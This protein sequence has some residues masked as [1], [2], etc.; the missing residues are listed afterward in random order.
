MTLPRAIILA[1]GVYGSTNGKTAHGLVRYSKRYEI[2]GVIDSEFS[3][4]DAGYVLDGKTRNIPIFSNVEEALYL[5][6]DILIIGAATDG[7]YLPAN[8]RPFILKAMLN[9]MNIVSGLHE[10]LSDDPEF[11]SMANIMGVQITDVRKMFLKKQEFFTGE[12]ENVKAIKVAVLG[13]DSAIGKRTTTIML[14]EALKDMGYSAIFVG[15][16]QT[17]WMQGAEYCALIDAMINDFVAGGIESEVVRAWKDHHPDFILIEGQGGILHPAYPGGFEI[18]A[19]A[20]PEAIVLQHAPKRLYYDGFEKYPI[21]DVKKFMDIIELLSGHSIVGITLNTEKMSDFEIPYYIQD[22][23]EKYRVPVDAPLYSGVS[24]IGR[25]IL[26]L[27]ESQ[28][29]I[30]EKKETV[31]AKGGY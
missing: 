29:E 5:K 6:P 22:Y 19:A 14:T 1:E 27:K 11:S 20:R 8:Y 15:T 24:K 9:G 21:P 3:G 2:V 13:T 10:F 26:D 23:E 25:A 16:G 4:M 7:G 12:I 17:G 28:V 18:I 31:I 30:Q